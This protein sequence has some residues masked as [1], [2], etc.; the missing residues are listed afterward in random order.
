MPVYFKVFALLNFICTKQR[1]LNLRFAY[2]TYF[3]LTFFSR[4]S[5]PS[6]TNILLRLAIE[7]VCL[8]RFSLRSLPGYEKIV[9]LLLWLRLLLLLSLTQSRSYNTEYGYVPNECKYVIFGFSVWRWR[10]SQM[11][12]DGEKKQQHTNNTPTLRHRDVEIQ[13]KS[14]PIFITK[15]I[16]I[17]ITVMMIMYWQRSNKVKQVS[18]CFCSFSFLY[19][20]YVCG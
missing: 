17:T 4:R 18:F 2:S 1:W 14:R 3:N 10:C 20:C 6:Q 8:I 16:T 19:I 15:S 12:A 9:V 11:G 7:K 5:L 13:I